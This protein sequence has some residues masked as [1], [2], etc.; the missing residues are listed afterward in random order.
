[1]YS[2]IIAPLANFKVLSSTSIVDL[3]GDGMTDIVLWANPP[4]QW[5]NIRVFFSRG[6]GSFYPKISDKT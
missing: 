6:D 3:D 4:R 2:I 5:E 1:M